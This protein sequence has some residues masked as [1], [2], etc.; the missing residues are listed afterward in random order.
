M[1]GRAMLSQ[2]C[3]AGLSTGELEE[4][5]GGRPRGERG[6]DRVVSSSTLAPQGSR[7]GQGG[8][9]C[10]WWG[11]PKSPRVWDLAAAEWIP[12]RVSP[13]YLLEMPV[14]RPAPRLSQERRGGRGVS[15]STPALPSW[16]AH[17]GLPSA[18]G[19]REPRQ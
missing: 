6:A 10:C 12:Q 4:E 1:P 17:S 16:V 14:L 18:S 13:V 15:V 5:A 11:A 7:E 8:A 9:L 19:P 3:Q 2:G